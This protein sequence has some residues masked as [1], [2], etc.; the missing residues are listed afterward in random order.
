VRSFDG[1]G[2]DTARSDMGAYELA[3]DSTFA[4]LPFLKK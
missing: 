3:K 1:D 2:N 4:N